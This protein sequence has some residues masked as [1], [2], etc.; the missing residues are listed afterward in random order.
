M[1]KDHILPFLLGTA[2]GA[3]GLT[4][5]ALM[6]DG[7]NTLTKTEEQKSSEKKNALIKKLNRLFFSLSGMQV[8]EMALIS[9]ISTRNVEDFAN[10]LFEL[11]RQEQDRVENYFYYLDHV[12]EFEDLQKNAISLYS[13][14]RENIRA[15]NC[16]LRERGQKTVS[17]L[18][19]KPSLMTCDSAYNSS[20]VSKI[21]LMGDATLNFIDTLMKKVDKLV[22]IL[23]EQSN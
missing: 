14:Y 16:L 7:D 15:A 22:S 12:E 6:S 3:I 20:D 4:A 19:I 8:K 5:L 9:S 11:Y 10:P 1:N 13:A 23:D 21:C 18:G 2:T 17:F